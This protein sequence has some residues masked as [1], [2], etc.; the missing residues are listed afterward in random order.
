MLIKF[1]SGAGCVY[2]EINFENC[3]LSLK[4]MKFEMQGVTVKCKE[5]LW[6]TKGKRIFQAFFD[7]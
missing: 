4:A 7:A 5:P 1:K 6:N 3:K 2:T